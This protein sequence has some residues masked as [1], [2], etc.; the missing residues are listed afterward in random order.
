MAMSFEKTLNAVWRQALVENADVV[1]LGAERYP[2]RLTTNRHLRRCPFTGNQTSSLSPLALRQNREAVHG[3]DKLSHRNPHI[4]PADTCSENSKRRKESINS[5]TNSCQCFWV[6]DAPEI[7][8]SHGSVVV[9]EFLTAIQASDVGSP[10]IDRS[11]SG[12]AGWD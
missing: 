6:M 2:V 12:Q 5:P 3:P 9:R 1:E 11:A 8:Q 7:C 10:A 4:Q